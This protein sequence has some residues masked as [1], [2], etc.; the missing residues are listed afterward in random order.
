MPKKR[1][2]KAG[3]GIGRHA[4]GRK[5]KRK[6]TGTLRSTFPTANVPSPSSSHADSPVQSLTTTK[7]SDQLH[8]KYHRNRAAYAV[9][10]CDK[11]DHQVNGLVTE[12]VDLRKCK[13]DQQILLKDQQILIKA[14]RDR[15]K[16]KDL[17]M[18][19][20]TTRLQSK[21]HKILQISQASASKIAT[22]LSARASR[23]ATALSKEKCKLKSMKRTSQ[24]DLLEVE[25]STKHFVNA[26][27]AKSEEKVVLIQRACAAN[28]A[29]SEE[30]LVR[31]QRACAATKAK[32]KEKVVRI[33]RACA[34]KKANSEKKVVCIQR[35]CAAA[36]DKLKVRPV[37]S[38]TF[39]CSLVSILIQLVSS[40]VSQNTTRKL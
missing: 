27:K 34:A 35:A 9:R 3:G 8:M 29:K 13:N 26:T 31:I 19:V 23:L 25:E 30:K 4:G 2:K 1:K 5:Q 6:R 14:V 17:I 33:Q 37:C 15:S 28:K 32:S 38:I 36:T 10:K 40:F 21:H 39:F 11:L 22:T 24:E 12:N 18:E 20:S 16:K 7:P